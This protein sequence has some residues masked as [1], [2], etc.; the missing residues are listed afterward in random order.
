M[1]LILAK[2]GQA[3]ASADLLNWPAAVVLVA[4]MAFLAFLA[5]LASR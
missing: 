3:V 5:W 1:T 2:H 4:G